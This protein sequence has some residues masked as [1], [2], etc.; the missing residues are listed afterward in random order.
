MPD[1]VAA[2]V[3]G[4]QGDTSGFIAGVLRRKMRADGLRVRR[5]QLGYVVTED[6]VESTRSR[7]AALPPISDEQHARNLE[8]LRQFDED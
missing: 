5:A 8:W 1:D 4:A 3:E 7:L 2:Y 6:E